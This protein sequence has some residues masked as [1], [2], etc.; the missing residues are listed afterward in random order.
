VSIGTRAPLLGEPLP[1][2]LMNTVWAG[3]DGVHDALADPAEA[4]A[5]L[6]AVAP[7][8][9]AAPQELGSPATST[10]TGTLISDLRNLR[11]ALRH[12][13]AEVTDDPR[14]RR[15]SGPRPSAARAA[16]VSTIN[17]AAAAAPAWP[18]LSWPDDGRATRQR[19]SRGPAARILLSAIADQA[20]S[21][22]AGTSQPG[23]PQ[24]RAC[25]GPGCVLYFVQQH[26][27]R[28][29]C[30]AGCGNRARVARHYHRHR[31]P[32]AG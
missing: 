24:L 15:R 5:W 19:Q 29:W 4:M 31:G 27:R 3:R 7:R 22:F 20:I 18:E 1:V 25:L 6:R 28:E 12:L 17:Q 13:A 11:D 30:S 26:P 23:Q 10:E 16:A 32:A 8:A 21:L 14:P 2:E 9:E